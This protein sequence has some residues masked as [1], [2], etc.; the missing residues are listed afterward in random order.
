MSDVLENRMMIVQRQIKPGVAEAV[1]VKTGQL[2]QIVDVAG[3]QVADFVAFSLNDR[4]EWGSTAVTRSTNGNIMMTMGRQLFSNR[5]RPLAELSADTVGR[6]D[7]LF[8]C[9]DRVRYESLGAAD[10]AHCRGALA[11]ALA[12][13]D[14]TPDMV[15]DPVNWFMNVAIKQRGDLEIR[16]P[17][18]EANDYVVLTALADLVV[19][20]SA[21]PQDL[22]PTNGMKPTDIVV[23]VFA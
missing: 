14:V 3:K 16:E 17:L 10:H 1:V 8:A 9:C 7:M 2:V 11:E 19:A 5:R 18:S 23:R 22:T 21:C 20:V 15:P 13:Y 6:H 12:G 4:A